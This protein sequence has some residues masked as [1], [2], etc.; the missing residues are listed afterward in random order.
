[1]KTTHTCI[2]YY[3]KIEENTDGKNTHQIQQK[4]AMKMLKQG[5]A[6]L[7]SLEFDETKIKRTSFGKPYYEGEADIYFNISHCPSAVA[8]AVSR[9]PV[10]IDVEG[11]RKIKYGTVKKCCSA[12]EMEYVL[13]EKDKNL[14][15]EATKRFLQVWTL[16]ESYVKMTGE[17]LR[18]SVDTIRFNMKS[19]QKEDVTNCYT[20]MYQPDELFIALS[21]ENF[22]ME[23]AEEI[24]L[25]KFIVQNGEK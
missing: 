3:A 15:D 24:L 21:I 19:F 6:E 13:G 20:K 25:Q 5:F 11:V 22:S 10:G 14:S 7:F 16:K 23:S 8:V 9:N 2:V 1:M 4:L 17:G 18:M 12:E